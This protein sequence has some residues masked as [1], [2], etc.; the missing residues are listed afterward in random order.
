[1]PIFWYKNKD[2]KIYEEAYGIVHSDCYT[3][4]GFIR[5]GCAACLFAGIKM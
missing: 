4:Y 1:M 5:T 2:R 3:K